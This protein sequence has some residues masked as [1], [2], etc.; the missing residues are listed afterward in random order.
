MQHTWINNMKFNV[1]Y[2]ERDPV[3]GSAIKG[4]DNPMTIPGQPIR[5]R[6]HNIERFV[7]IRGGAYFFLPGLAA[8]RT[9]AGI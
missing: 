3:I 7:T 5:K 6:L 4:E 2:D 1:L 8:L 9:L